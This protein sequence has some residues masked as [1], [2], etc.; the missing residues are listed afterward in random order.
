M[1]THRLSPNAGLVIES[2]TSL[3]CAASSLENVAGRSVDRA[4]E[5]GH[6]GAVFYSERLE[7]HEAKIFDQLDQGVIQFVELC[8]GV[9]T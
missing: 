4:E 6:A 5:A 8:I 3:V 1:I 9:G 7:A 2:A